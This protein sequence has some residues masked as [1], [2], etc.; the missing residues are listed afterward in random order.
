L[1][2]TRITFTSKEEVDDNIATLEA[3][4]MNEERAEFLRYDNAKRVNA[5]LFDRTNGA[6]TGYSQRLNGTTNERYGLAKSMMVMSGDVINMEV[7]AKY[8]D[9]NTSNWNTALTNLMSQIAANAAGV[10]YEGTT[11]S[12]STASFPHAGLL[13]TSS[14]TGGPKAYLN[15]LLFDKEFNYVTGGYK[16]LSATPKETGQDVAHERLFFDNLVIT[17]AGYLYIYL[18]N[19]NETPVEVFFDDFTVE[20]IKSPVVQADDYYP[21]GLTFNSYQRENST[22][23]Q[24]LY[25]GIERQDELDLGWDLAQFRAY[26]PTIGRF[27]QIDPVIKLHESPYAWN[28]NNPLLYADPTGADSTQRAQAVAMAQQYVEQNCGNTYPT[29]EQKN[30]GQFREGPSGIV[31]CSGLVGNCVVAGG[32]SNPAIEGTGRGVE[33]ITQNT[34]RIGDKDDM[35]KVEVGTI[36]TINNT[37]GKGDLKPENDYKHVGI[38]TEVTRGDDG[39]ITSMKMIHSSGNPAKGKSG[40]NEVSLIGGNTSQSGYWGKRITGFYKWDTKPDN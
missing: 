24:Y 29:D 31:D 6:S 16:R 38:I 15:Y 13:N 11:Y 21:F 3:A 14:S 34:E 9:T 35:S 36:V 39:N 33:R 40:P 26:D 37:S 23:N 27:M 7:Y 28:T 10:V 12:T 5:T 2:N 20:H 1:G 8:V 22:T 18:S 25:N 19:E 17:E 30:N 4:N 32:E